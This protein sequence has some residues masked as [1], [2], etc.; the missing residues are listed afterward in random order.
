MASVAASA[1][2]RLVWVIN[3]NHG[4]LFEFTAVCDKVTLPELCPSC[5]AYE[6][7]TLHL[8]VVQIFLR[9]N[10]SVSVVDSIHFLSVTG[11]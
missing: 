9:K 1:G 8:A 10:V 6:D 7:V 11:S 2:T 3:H 4:S 5:F